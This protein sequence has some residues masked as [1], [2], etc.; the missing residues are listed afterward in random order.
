MNTYSTIF[1]GQAVPLQTIPVLAYESFL[2]LNTELVRSQECHCVNYY[3]FAIGERIKLICCI[4]D[5]AKHTIYVSSAEIARVGSGP[6][7][8]L[9]ARHLSFHIF[10]RELQ[11]N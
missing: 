8:S 7:A 1:N 9:T 6:I 5:D 2:E 4:A 11:E 3:G 10:E